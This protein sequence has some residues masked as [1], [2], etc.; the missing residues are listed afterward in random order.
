MKKIIL[1]VAVLTTAAVLSAPVSA[2]TLTLFKT[3]DLVDTG[4]NDVSD[5]PEVGS[6]PAGISSSDL[7]LGAGISGQNWPNALDVTG[8][9]GNASLADS[10]A[11]NDYLTVTVAADA[12]NT[13]DFSNFHVV[14]G[15]NVGPGLMHLMS[16][17]TGFTDGD[18][19]AAINHAGGPGGAVPPDEHDIDLSSVVA[20]QGAAGAVEFR[21]YVSQ[22]ANRVG[23]GQ[24]FNGT[25]RDDL[26]IDGTVN[27]IPEPSSLLLLGFGALMSTF[28]MR[29]K[30]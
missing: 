18:E 8:F 17:A 1:L 6:V 4:G 27:V 30:K 19:I 13:I 10:L 15:A 22:T 25:D 26:R 9:F 20:L 28:S 7:T 12:G 21:L 3:S 11:G 24:S 5:S 14:I 16:S 23:I 2:A 29:R